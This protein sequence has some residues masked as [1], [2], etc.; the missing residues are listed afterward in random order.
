MSWLEIDLSA[1][2]GNVRSLKGLVGKN[3]RLMA[4]V[5]ADGY[6]HG[7]CRVAEIALKNGA[8][9]LGVARVEE[10][11]DLRAYGLD[12]PILVMGYTP[13]GLIREIVDHNLIQT[14][15]STDEA[16]LL[17][18]SAVAKNTV[19]RVH[20]KVDTGM[21]RLGKNVVTEDPRAGLTAAVREAVAI[22]DQPGLLLEGVYTHFAAADDPDKTYTRTQMALFEQLTAQLASAGLSG[23]IRHAANSAALIDFPETHLDMVRPGIALY[24]LYPS[25]TVDHQRVSLQPAMT[26]K[27]RIVQLKKV[28]AGTKISYGSTYTAPKSTTLAVVP[29]GYADGYNRWLSSRGHML[30]SGQKAPVVG[31]VCMDLTVLDVGGID[32]VA[33]EDEVVVLGRQGQMQISADEIAAA[34]ETIHYE[35]VS[36]ITHRVAR[37]FV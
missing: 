13:P 30:V 2:A 6:G 19:A 15:W 35:V 28:P 26:W 4:V 34:R 17:S 36:A 18:Q 12:A 16:R 25:V 24:G 8:S 32:P 10:G 9:M 20:F 31:R 1:I 22:A 27:T 3:C 11:V 33:V 7:M 23:L 29:V 14:V 21:G 5:K 37:V